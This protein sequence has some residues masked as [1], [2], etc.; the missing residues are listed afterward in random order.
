MKKRIITGLLAA[1]M[2]FQAP[3]AVF[4]SE[5]SQTAISPLAITEENEGE[6]ASGGLVFDAGLEP[7]ASAPGWTSEVNRLEAEAGEEQALKNTQDYGLIWPYTEMKGRKLWRGE[8]TKLYFNLYSRG[9][10]AD[11]Y[12]IKLYQGAGTNGQVLGDVPKYFPGQ[13]GFWVQT[14]GLN[15][16]AFDPGTYTVECWALSYINGA[17]TETPN[18]RTSFQFQV[19]NDRIPLQSISMNTT[20]KQ[21]RAEQ[22]MEVK[23]TLSPADTTDDPMVK[24]SSTNEAA[25]VAYEGFYSSHTGGVTAKGNGIA[26]ITAQVGGKA[27][28]CIFAVSPQTDLDFPF[29]DILIDTNNWKYVNTKYVYSNGIMNGISG[30]NWFKPDDPLNRAMFATVLYRMANSPATSFSNRFSDVKDGQYY[31]KAV[32]W[33]N[34]KKIVSGMG[35]GSYGVERNITREQIAKMLYEYAKSSG[36]DVSARKSLDSF[37]DQSSVSGWAKEYMQWATAAGLISGKPNA[38]GGYRLD[39]KGEAT[40]AECAKMLT[41]F[42]Q[43]YK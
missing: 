14:L 8:K 29:S 40:R 16:E 17:Y 11:Q 6:E 7:A 42:D 5:S 25:V 23:V 36:K 18:S 34:D 35:D 28:T 21:M 2:A 27:A 43:K 26:Y 22:E 32:I 24:W 30:T 9:S 13:K 4:A 15:T 20:G 37:T 39:P 19:V 33:A 38:G 1:V 3:T 31:S 41:M 12:I 10:S